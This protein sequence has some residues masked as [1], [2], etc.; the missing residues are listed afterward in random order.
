M[1]SRLDYLINFWTY[2]V[3]FFPELGP[4]ENFDILKLS[5]RC[6]KLFDLGALNLDS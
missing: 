3:H 2:S 1:M 5:A 6:L 4:F